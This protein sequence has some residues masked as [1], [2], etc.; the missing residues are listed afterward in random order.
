[1]LVMVIA[2]AVF[3]VVLAEVEHLLPQPNGHRQAQAHHRA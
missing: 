3:G 1:M 2:H